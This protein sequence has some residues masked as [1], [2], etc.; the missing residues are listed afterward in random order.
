MA[1]FSV[2]A[3][4]LQDAEPV[5]RVHKQSI[6]RLCS[7]VYS[8]HQIGE[9]SELRSPRDYEEFIRDGSVMVVEGPEGVVGFAVFCAQTGE[10]DALYVHPDYVSHGIGTQLL[11]AVESQALSHGLS[12]ITLNATLN[13]AVFYERRGYSSLGPTTYRLPSGIEL[14]CV[15]MR[16]RLTS[17]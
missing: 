12:S 15:R 8:P 4:A 14:A 1:S 11:A 10:L 3:A 16:R 6:L 9:W 17:K 13:S 7:G 2:R 5:Y